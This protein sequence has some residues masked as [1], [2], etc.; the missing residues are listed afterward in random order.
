[1]PLSSR[2]RQALGGQQIG[3][4]RLG[5]R[6][7]VA[8]WLRSIARYP[9]PDGAAAPPFLPLTRDSQMPLWPVLTLL[10]LL[11]PRMALNAQASALP[12]GTRVRVQ[13]P[14]GATDTVRPCR[15]VMGRLLA[16]TGDGLLIEDAHGVMRRIDLPTGSRFERSAGYRRHTLLGLGLGSLV[17]LGTGALLVSGCTKGGSDDELCGLYYL[18]TVPAGAALGTLVGA[19]TR[20][21]R[22]E[23]VPAPAT[24]LYVWPLPGRAT[25]SLTVR[26]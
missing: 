11:L 25:V 1:M 7:D 2:M 12:P 22:W 24:A 10:A 5:D 26:F 19:L 18:F 15:A 9:D 23:A 4:S 3:K 13:P 6:C 16:P 8:W 21:E 17:G 20:T 14:C